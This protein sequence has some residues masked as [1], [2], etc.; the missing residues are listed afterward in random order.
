MWLLVG[1]GNPGPSYR[2]TRHNLGFR[3]L[4]ALANSLGGVS[5]RSKFQGEIASASYA[6]EEL[7]L[8][9]PGTFMNLS[10]ASVQPA[11]A[12]YK[13]TPSSILVCHDEL[14]LPFGTIRLKSGG[15]HA[16]HNGL[17]SLIERLGEA[18]FARLRLGIGR[19]SHEGPSAVT[20]HVLGS[21]PP[22]EA[23]ELPAIERAATAVI[24]LVLSQ[25]LSSAMNQV[26]SSV[27]A[28]P[29]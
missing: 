13:I 29:R 27:N 14:D 6:G 23:A 7:L 10:G 22:H 21:W 11:A 2:D 16:G 24:K 19:P 26:N 28:K 9:R 4:D 12:F 20:D 8:L 5:W 1:L 18:S 3:V 17:K 25:G 15:G